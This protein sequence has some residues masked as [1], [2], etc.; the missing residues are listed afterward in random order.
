M[1]I[2][3]I[4]YVDTPSTDNPVQGELAGSP[5]ESIRNDGFAVTPRRYKV[6]DNQKTAF[7]EAMLV[8]SATQGTA[9]RIT[10]PMD[11]T[12]AAL[13]GYVRAEQ[14][15]FEPFGDTIQKGT[16][17]GEEFAVYDNWTGTVRYS[18]QRS[19][20]EEWSPSYEFLTQR[21]F[22]Y[23]WDTTP[24][25]ALVQAE[26]PGK[27]VSKG[28]WAVTRRWMPTIPDIYFNALGMV[29]TGD[30]ESTM[31]GTDFPAG[32]LLYL[33][34][35]IRPYNNW[36]GG[37]LF[38]VTAMFAYRAKGWNKFWLARAATP[39]WY[40]INDAAGNP[41]NPYSNADAAFSLMCAYDEG[42]V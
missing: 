20:Y 15:D 38:D 35:R 13:P 19:I 30:V 32:T 3:A 42:D 7:V 8:D 11:Y 33:N 31:Y 36:N 5:H 29:N 6:P 37:Q 2:T 21:A 12:H 39:G 40:G 25:L 26:F 1:N 16:E 17:D 9:I 34:P 10:K 18:S 14:V 23:T 27:L 28:Q 4:Q 41:Y 22:G 24:A